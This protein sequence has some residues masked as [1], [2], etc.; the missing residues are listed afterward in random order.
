MANGE[1]RGRR[2]PR[3][4]VRHSHFA[5]P[6]WTLAIRH[7]RKNAVLAM[8]RHP[9]FACR[10]PDERQ[11]NPGRHSRCKDRS[12]I[13][14]RSSGLQTKGGG[15]PKGASNHC[16]RGASRCRHLKALRARKRPDVGG[17]SPSGAPTAALARATERSNSAQAAL[18]A[19]ERAKALPAP[20]IA[21]KRSTPHPGR[22]A[23]GDDAR[24]ARGRGYKPRPQ[25]PHSL[26]RSAVAGDVPSMREI[27]GD[28]N[29]NSD[30]C[31]WK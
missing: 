9:S 3:F 29:S 6:H 5:A 14:L 13:S 7:S 11:R 4:V 17:R 19:K 25:E 23:G 12:R 2:L 30:D 27:R 31:Q 20:S 8:R 21:L 18:H 15:A 16:P 28:R 22:S 1:W 26:H 24:A 10:S